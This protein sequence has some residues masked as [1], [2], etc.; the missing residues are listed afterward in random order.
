M[1][2]AGGQLDASADL[3]ARK[4]SPILFN[5]T[6]DE[7]GVDMSF[8]KRDLPARDI[9]LYLAARSTFITPTMLLQ[10]LCFPKDKF[11]ITLPS[12]CNLPKTV[13]F[14]V[15]QRTLCERFFSFHACYLA[16][17]FHLHSISHYNKICSLGIIYCFVLLLHPR[18]KYCH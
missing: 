7:P 5:R 2:E 13:A 10:A 15:F 1:T 16:H 9:K 14:Q 18:F 17:L 6:L 12:K 11:H 8:W 4:E 3:S